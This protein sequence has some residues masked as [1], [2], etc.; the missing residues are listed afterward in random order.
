MIHS[1][2]L[3]VDNHPN[4]SLS[5]IVHSPSLPMV[6]LVRHPLVEGTVSFHIHN[7]PHFVH[8]HVRGQV[9]RPWEEDGRDRWALDR[10]TS[11]FTMFLEGTGE[12]ISRT[13][14]VT[15]GIHH[16]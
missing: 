10:Y 15:L 1:P 5:N 4:S 13:A 16:R 9:L 11:A 2:D 8:F 12:E 6:E 3:L 14:A 7:I